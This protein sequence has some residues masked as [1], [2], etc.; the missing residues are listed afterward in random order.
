MHCKYFTDRDTRSD[1]I[2][3]TIT[4]LTFLNRFWIHLTGC[5]LVNLRSQ[6]GGDLKEK[7]WSFRPVDE[8]ARFQK[9][10]NMV[11]GSG[12]RMKEIFNDID[13]TRKNF[14]DKCDLDFG[15][16]EYCKG[17][18]GFFDGS[19]SAML[20]ECDPTEQSKTSVTFNEFYSLMLS[21]TNVSNCFTVRD[22]LCDWQAMSNRR[23]SLQML[24]DGVVP[25]ELENDDDESGDSEDEF[26][27][28]ESV[29][30]STPEDTGDDGQVRIRSISGPTSSTRVTNVVRDKL[31][32]ETVLQNINQVIFTLGPP[33]CE[34]P[35]YPLKHGLICLTNFRLALL[36]KSSRHNRRSWRN[37]TTKGSVSAAVFL[38][39]APIGTRQ[40]T[41]PLTAINRIETDL[42]GIN[43]LTLLV[44][45][46]DL[47]VLRIG[48]PP[49]GTDPSRN[50]TFTDFFANVLKS[51]A[52]PASGAREFF[53]F[54]SLNIL[55]LEDQRHAALIEEAEA[56]AARRSSCTTSVDHDVGLAAAAL[57]TGL[58]VGSDKSEQA[59]SIASLVEQHSGDILVSGSPRERTSTVDLDA[60]TSSVP[61]PP[62]PP[63]DSS[64]D[65][66]TAPPLADSAAIASS[67]P[68]VIKKKLIRMKSISEYMPSSQAA[69]SIAVATATT[70]DSVAV[71]DTTTITTS[72]SN[73]IQP[74]PPALPIRRRIIDGWKKFTPLNEYVRQGLLSDDSTAGELST[75]G[76][77]TSLWR[78]W[79][80]NYQLAETYPSAFILPAALTEREITEAA[81]FRSKHR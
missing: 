30:D 51:T 20:S 8:S 3:L 7:R 42:G 44:T 21:S 12:W 11:I 72:T 55:E 29:A 33:T 25:Q 23:I 26:A 65:S 49:T 13:R 16:S 4:V 66:S 1:H 57:A 59:G 39:D 61:P 63:V 40:Y 43:G 58:R 9:I 68:V 27:K 14:V 80:D 48:F 67:P 34:K 64:P 50:V 75:R 41:I 5:L 2:Q 6:T 76:S 52:F 18:T 79:T 73:A 37:S 22:V 62:P 47:R 46:K 35:G 69:L 78:L 74:V 53:A 17:E 36:E 70:A 10:V 56:T 24:Q 32:G 38:H 31:P 77:P 28:S 60:S 45:C 19:A 15:I 54:R 81:R 71:A